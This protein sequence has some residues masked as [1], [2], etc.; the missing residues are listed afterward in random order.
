[1]KCDMVNR[2]E[3]LRFR[4]NSPNLRR[5]M[6]ANV[7]SVTRPPSRAD[8]LKAVAEDV[9]TIPAQ[10]ADE[11]SAGVIIVDSGSARRLIHSLAELD[12]IAF[13]RL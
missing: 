7:A 9:E 6:I 1:M 13:A 8:G 5:Q 2:V 4:T 12:V 3:P 10:P 11:E